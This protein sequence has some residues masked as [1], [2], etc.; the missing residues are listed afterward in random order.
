M[1]EKGPTYNL[2]VRG[3][4]G[5]HISQ[6]LMHG[7]YT[8]C[9]YNMRKHSYILEDIDLKWSMTIMI[10]AV[11]AE[12]LAHND[13]ASPLRPLVTFCFLLICPGMAFIKLLNFHDRLHEIVLA[14]ALSLAMD[15]I[16]ATIFVY[17]GL[18]SPELILLS[19]I[20]LSLFGVLCQVVQWLRQR[21]SSVRLH[22]T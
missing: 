5:S 22:S 1:A 2:H 12:L 16:F 17:S 10:S 20:V 7:L 4:F 19:L 6:P 3:D 9:I 15:L 18:W 8:K 14:V 13:S 21:T 11:A